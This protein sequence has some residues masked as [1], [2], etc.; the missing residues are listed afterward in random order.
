MRIVLYVFTHYK[1]EDYE[2]FAQTIQIS[3][4]HDY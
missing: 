2:H 3:L 4:I 1:T